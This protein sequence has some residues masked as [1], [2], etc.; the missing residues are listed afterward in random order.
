GA[1]PAL[2]DDPTVRS[3]RGVR[4]VPEDL[5]AARVC[6]A[7]P[8]GSRR[9][10]VGGVRLLVAGGGVRTAP[11]RL[12]AAP[13][14]VVDVPERMGGGLLYVVGSQV[15]RSETWLDAP[16]LLLRTASAVNDVFLGLDRAYLAMP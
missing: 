10:S 1:A 12:P 2:G 11:E 15:W 7:E 16:R 14:S 9:A 13:T 6:G 8:N 4:L 3:P 5:L